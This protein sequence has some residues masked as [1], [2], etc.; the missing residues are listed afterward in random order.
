M[1]VHVGYTVPVIHS[2]S[3][4]WKIS[5]SEDEASKEQLE[6]HQE[7]NHAHCWS[8]SKVRV[9]NLKITIWHFPNGR[10]HDRNG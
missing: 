9:A 6:Q 10:F 8:I 3:Y 2:N 4:V 1:S 7:N 5:V